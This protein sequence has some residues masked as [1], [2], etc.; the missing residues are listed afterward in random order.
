MVLGTGGS[1]HTS[2]TRG[3]RA[4]LRELIN[5]PEFAT[6]AKNIVVRNETK[7]A[8]EFFVPFDQLGT[9]HIGRTIGVWGAV[10]SAA[11]GGSIAWLNRGD[12][13]ITIKIPLS[14]FKKLKTIYKFTSASELRGAKFLLIGTFNFHLECEITDVRQIALQVTKM[15]NLARSNG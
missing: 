4:V 5:R 2:A 11:E 12:Q 15:A 10:F 1:E 6:S 9:Q 14:L 7:P 8:S 3:V 13:R